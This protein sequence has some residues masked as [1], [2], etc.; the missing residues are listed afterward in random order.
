MKA[1][2]SPVTDYKIRYPITIIYKKAWRPYRYSLHELRPQEDAQQNR[3][4]QPE[5]PRRYVYTTPTMSQADSAHKA[6][7]HT[8][9]T[10]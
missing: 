2:M 4:E 5:T 1:D 7:S 8:Y 3:N 10:A 6:H 9:D